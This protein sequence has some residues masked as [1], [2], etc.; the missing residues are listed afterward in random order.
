[1]SSLATAAFERSIAKRVLRE[2]VG[3]EGGEVR[4]RQELPRLE[5]RRGDLQH[6]AEEQRPPLEP[7][8]LVLEDLPKLQKLRRV[9]DHRRDHMDGP[10]TR[11]P[12]ER[13]HLLPEHLRS[14]QQQP[15]PA[16]PPAPGSPPGGDPGTP[17]SCRPRGRAAGCR[18][19]GPPWPPPPP[20]SAG[21]APP[22]PAAAPA[23][24][25]RA[26][27]DRALRPR[28]G[29]RAPP[30]ARRCARCSRAPAAPPPAARCA[31]CEGPSGGAPRRP[32]GS[33]G[34]GETIT[35]PRSP[36]ISRSAPK[37]TRCSSRSSLR[38]TAGSPM[39]RARIAACE[40]GAHALGE[41]PEGQVVDLH[42]QRGRQLGDHQN[43]R[44]AELAL[45]HRAVHRH[46]AADRRGRAPERRQQ[47]ALELVDV[48]YA[49]GRPLRGGERQPLSEALEGV[50][51]GALGGRSFPSNGLGEGLPER[52]VAEHH[53]LHP[54]NRRL[55]RA[56]RLV[57]VAGQHLQASAHRGEGHP[58]P[59]L[60]DLRAP[61]RRPR[62][63]EEPGRRG[64]P[65]QAPLRRSVESRDVDALW[66]TAP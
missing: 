8:G 24:G 57:G 14:G 58:Q 37:G 63:T 34:S 10:G 45:A 52:L 61:R 30:R 62:R 44:V 19:P 1:M 20:S 48:L 28:R 40:V 54:E 41:Q 12:R 50:D 29:R 53:A 5:A 32:R 65:A 64:I 16:K 49:A 18:P 39:A 46:P 33:P 56:H 59:A 38:L 66:S 4:R 35:S 11:G 3:A 21:T 6:R 25:A 17:R 36:S 22:R 13:P 26:P 23:R 9:D 51:H 42:H 55:A 27:C 31:S 43:V 2:V 47:A 60:L 7:P 15:R